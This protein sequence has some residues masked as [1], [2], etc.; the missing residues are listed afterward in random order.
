MKKFVVYAW[1]SDNEGGFGIC[2]TEQFSPLLGYQP[3]SGPWARP[4]QKIGEFNTVEELAR[5][6]FDSCSGYYVSF[7]EAAT[8][9][10]RLFDD[11]KYFS[12]S[13]EE[14]TNGKL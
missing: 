3:E 10:E 2:R 7:E 1:N 14:L 13:K 11:Y 9:A 5:L 6:L 4:S 12:E 8:D